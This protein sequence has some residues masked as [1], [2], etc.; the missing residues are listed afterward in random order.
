MS[1]KDFEE[2]SVVFSA[3]EVAKLCGVVNQTAINWIK[4]NH[5]KAYQTP[6]GQFRVYPE[7]L[8]DFMM[9]RN[10]R[11][12]EELKELCKPEDPEGCP[13]KI[14][15][16][17]DDEAFNSVSVKLLAKHF[18]DAQIFQAFD[19]FEAGAKMVEKQPNCLI[20]DIGLPGIDGLRLCSR[21]RESDAFGKP[22]IIVVTG[23]EDDDTEKKCRDLGVRYYFKKPLV[24]SELAAAI[25]EAFNC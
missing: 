15:F 24:V 9:S 21:I 1:K 7:D 10:M 22:E 8:Y 20:L 4:G 11:I 12:P 23:L 2:K 5:L 25:G 19:G 14:L 18:P 16:V 13:L 17:D 6:G 3:L